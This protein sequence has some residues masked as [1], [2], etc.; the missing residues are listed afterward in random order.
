MELMRI[1]SPG[2]ISSI[3]DHGRKGF[4][5]LAIPQ[6][7]FLDSYSAS[8]ANYLVGKT[9]GAEAIEII[10]GTFKCT[11]LTA[12]NI[13]VAGVS[14]R[15]Q[16][17]GQDHEILQQIAVSSGD[18]LSIR[19]ELTYLGIGAHLEADKH[20][21]SVSTLPSVHLGGIQ[22]TYLSKNQHLSGQ[23]T[24]VNPAYLSK[25]LAPRKT[26][27]IRVLKG[28]EFEGDTD[29]FEEK[30]WSISTASNRIGLRLQNNDWYQDPLEMISVPVFPGTIQLP[31]SNQPIVLLNDAQTTGGYPRI[32][33]VI[34]ADLPR[35][36]RL[37]AGGSIRFKFVGINEAREIYTRQST[38][39]KH[40][41]KANR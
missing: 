21:G 11:F 39:I 7:G 13:S 8:L 2:I 9:P 33:Q 1:N 3:Q 27:L 16:V 22:G 18:E 10:G 34:A 14:T 12:M 5:H 41:L 40:V 6:S 35:I 36:G 37:I 20:F 28:L 25:D 19:G 23:P 17:N 38:F 4:R 29:Q 26:S 30:K 24:K 32:A 15:L 31:P